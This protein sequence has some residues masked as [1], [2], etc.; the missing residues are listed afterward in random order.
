M[1]N[2]AIVQ[3]HD[4]ESHELARKRR[5]NIKYAAKV[6]KKANKSNPTTITP[7][8]RLREYSNEDFRIHLGSLWCNP[9]DEELQ[10]KSSS[11]KD[12]LE[13]NDHRI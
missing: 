2:F 11:I 7:E 8:D 3:S 9:C 10:V 12:H 4:P 6:I 5:S 1:E 13:C